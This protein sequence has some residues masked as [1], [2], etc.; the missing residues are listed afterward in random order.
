MAASLVNPASSSGKL[1]ASMKAAEAVG[2]AGKKVK[3]AE[4]VIDANKATKG[5]PK[6]TVPGAGDNIPPKGTGDIG[7]S[8]PKGG[9][10]INGRKY[11]EHALERMAPNT[12]EVRAELST[13]AHQKATEKGLKSGTKEYHEFVTKYVD[14]RGITPT[15][16]ED[17]IKNTP[18]KPGKY[19]GTFTYQSEKVTVITNNNGDIVTVIPR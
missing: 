8:M 9:G 5:S 14:P 13:R 11:S 17:A 2:D 12:P 10:V 19:D 15:V 3:Q 4:K 16:V 1:K 6:L 7:W 18:I